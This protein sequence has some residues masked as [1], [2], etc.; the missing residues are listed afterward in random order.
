VIYQ[1]VI[2]A[3]VA[4]AAKWRGISLALIK[5]AGKKMAPPTIYRS[6]DDGGKA[7]LIMLV[8]E[9]W[10]PGGLDAAREG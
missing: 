3:I 9:V 6:T 5:G 1:S 8:V 4:A 7:R 2:L 10:P